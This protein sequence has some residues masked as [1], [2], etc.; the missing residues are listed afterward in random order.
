MTRHPFA[1]ITAALL[2]LVCSLANA[3]ITAQ[4]GAVTGTVTDPT[5]ASIPN[6]KVLLT[7]EKGIV[8]EK[9][10]SEAGT[11]TFPLLEPGLYKITVEAR[12]FSKAAV[13]GVRVQITETTNLP[14]RLEVGT[15]TIEI[16]VAAE[17]VA[18]N[19]SAATLGNTLPGSVIDQMPLATRNFTNLLALNAGTS[20][21]LPNAAAAG[22]ASSTV[23]VNGQRGTGNNL[24][25]NGV[26]ANNIASNNFG[27][28]AIPA[29]DTL[30][31]FRVQTS[32][33]DAS[34]GKTSGGNINAIT[35][36]GGPEYHGQLYEF[37][38]NEK[39]NANDFF[40]NKNGSAP[41]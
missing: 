3:Q 40:F 4:T 26:D 23:F 25:I 21:D 27:N 14:V 33:Y 7:S 12:G 18:I 28:V 37:F 19:T 5:G 30:E 1:V 10:T 16:S 31:E 20:S 2:L 24:V 17:A 32:L 11:F 36:G 13:N 9:A 29:P 39:L 38:R 34:Q 6:A 41:P 15:E 22:R 35:K 8:Q